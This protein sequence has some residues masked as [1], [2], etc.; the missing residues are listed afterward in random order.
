M[1]VHPHDALIRL[2]IVELRKQGATIIHAD[3]IASYLQPAK[4]GGSIPDIAATINGTAV[5][6]EAES[7][8]GLAASHTKAQLIGFHQKLRPVGGQLVLAV[9]QVDSFSARQL[10]AGLSSNIILWTF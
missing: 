6:V 10:I 4:V 9:N 5:L 2:S 7:A 8:E 3:H 1:G